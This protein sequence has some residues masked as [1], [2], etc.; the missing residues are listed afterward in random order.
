MKEIKV[1]CPHCGKWLQIERPMQRINYLADMNIEEMSL[2]QLIVA[3]RSASTKLSRL[4]KLQKTT[5]TEETN[6]QIEDLKIKYD[7]IVDKILKISQT[8]E[9]KVSKVEIP[10]FDEEVYR[11]AEQFN[12]D[13][14]E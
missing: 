6:K 3:R 1:V 10:V 13:N 11:D 2:S 4:R 5:Y 14:Q 8:Q 12:T 9:F 7:A